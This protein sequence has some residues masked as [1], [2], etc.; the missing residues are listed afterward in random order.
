MKKQKTRPLI[1]AGFFLWREFGHASMPLIR[2]YMITTPFHV[3]TFRHFFHN[4]GTQSNTDG[5]DL[6]L[7]NF[8]YQ[9][10]FLLPVLCDI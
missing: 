1:Q 5:Q 3:Q 10:E 9:K 4:F 7:A 8:Q 6:F 2:I